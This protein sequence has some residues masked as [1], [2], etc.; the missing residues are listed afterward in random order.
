MR[1]LLVI[2]EPQSPRHLFE[3]GDGGGRGR[4]KGAHGDVNHDIRAFDGDGDRHR[5]RR[6]DVPFDAV[7][8]RQIEWHVSPP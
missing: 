5:H 1:D 6:D 2:A 3:P 4:D 7:E 8:V